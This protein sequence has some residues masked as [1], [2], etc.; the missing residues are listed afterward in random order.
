MWTAPAGPKS[1][2]NDADAIESAGHCLPPLLLLL[3]QYDG[4]LVACYSDHPLVPAL[5]QHTQKPIVGIF[6]ASV[7]T[8]LQLISREQTFGIVSTGKIWEKLLTNAVHQFLGSPSEAIV[9]AGVGRSYP[10]TGVETTGLNATD[11][12][13]APA[14]E[15]RKRMKEAT[16]RLLD[17]NSGGNVGAICL[18][19]AGMV[20]LEEI[21]R[22]T[23][24]EKLGDADGSLIRIIDGVRAGVG[25]LH[26]LA[27]G[28][29]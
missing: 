16:W 3:D 21:V 10:F 15:V 14:A 20:G 23:C 13:D 8:S 9:R 7:T 17:R 18:G 1:I 4:F 22:E 19:C 5:Q 28:R 6:Q 24:M 25:I 12:H 2:N 29:F 27:R 26:G 11:L